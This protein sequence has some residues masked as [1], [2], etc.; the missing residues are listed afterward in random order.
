MEPEACL[1]DTGGPDDNVSLETLAADED[2]LF[3]PSSL[4]MAAMEAS[5]GGSLDRPVVPL[6]NA[7]QAR[8]VETLES[9]AGGM[10]FVAGV[11]RRGVA[12]VR[13]IRRAWAQMRWTVWAD[14]GEVQRSA[15]TELWWSRR[16]PNWGGYLG[17]DAD[18]RWRRPPRPRSEVDGWLMESAGRL[19]VAALPEGNGPTPEGAWLDRVVGALVD[20]G[21]MQ[22]GEWFEVVLG[23]DARGWSAVARREYHPTGSV[24][25]RTLSE[26]RRAVDAEPDRLVAAEGSTGYAELRAALRAVTG[27][28]RWPQ[29]DADE[30]RAMIAVYSTP[31]S[32]HARAVHGRLD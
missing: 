22:D 13:L 31:P 27:G 28:R 12:A 26:L 29:L 9:C 10:L 17:T 2:P 32:E 4:L 1:I 18:W 21:A 6:L 14:A 8:G 30:R 24:E 20:G 19:A 15:R 23:R 5:G 7:L 3:R 11:D 16:V 25:A